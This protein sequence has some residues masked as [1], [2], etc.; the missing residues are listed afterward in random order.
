M[1]TGMK[2][3]HTR[4]SVIDH[5]WIVNICAIDENTPP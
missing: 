1:M 3:E 5:F 2:I 4:R